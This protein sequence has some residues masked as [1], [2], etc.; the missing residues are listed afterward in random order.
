MDNRFA[1]PRI[2]FVGHLSLPLAALMGFLLHEPMTT[3]FPA[4]AFRL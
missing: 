1:V 2:Q 4:S 3:A